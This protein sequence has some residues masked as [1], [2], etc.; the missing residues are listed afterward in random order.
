MIWF[1]EPIDQEILRQSLSATACD[2]FLAVGTSALVNP[3][4][5]LIHQAKQNGA[6]TVEIN[7]EATPASDLVD[8]AFHGPATGIL[9]QIEQRLIPSL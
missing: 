5:S 6:F 2:I 1:G 3:A 4:A 9:E 8:L 7:V